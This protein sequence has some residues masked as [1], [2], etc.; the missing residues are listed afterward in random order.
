VAF[1]DDRIHGDTSEREESPEQ[2]NDDPTCKELFRKLV[3]C[4]VKTRTLSVIMSNLREGDDILPQGP[5][6]EQCQK[7]EDGDGA[8]DVSRFAQSLRIVV[9]IFEGDVFVVAIGTCQA[10]GTKSVPS[11]MSVMEGGDCNSY[12]RGSSN[13]S[14]TAVQTWVSLPDRCDVYSTG[15]S[16][17]KCQL[18]RVSIQSSMCH[19]S[20]QTY[21]SN[22]C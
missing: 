5:H 18:F 1:L 19:R 10:N 3:C 6:D 11:I 13:A 9:R 2:R 4:A 15:E 20:D 12:N 17:G 16:F 21:P 22:D 7:Q 8:C 14:D